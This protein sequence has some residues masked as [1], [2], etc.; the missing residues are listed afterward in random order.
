MGIQIAH[1]GRKASNRTPLNG[2]GALAAN[3]GSWQ[4]LGPS[5]AAYGDWPAPAALDGAGLARVKAEF[6]ATTE[7]SVRVGFDVAQ[8]HAAHGYL[9]HQFLS[10]L[11]NLRPDGYGGSIEGRMRFP[12]E[13]FDD[14]RAV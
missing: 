11:S 9:L 2:G 5:A 8:L 10:T 13:V 14:C 7:R 1:A 12:L 6:V 4:T 3:E